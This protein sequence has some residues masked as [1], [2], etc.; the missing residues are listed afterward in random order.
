MKQ[1]AFSSS[2][3][4]SSEVQLESIDAVRSQLA[5]TAIIFSAIIG[6]IVLAASLFREMAI[7]RQGVMLLPVGSGLV[8]LAFLIFFRR[9]SYNIRAF[10]IP[11]VLFIWGSIGLFRFGLV[12]MGIP[13]L[14]TSCI[15]ITIFLGRRFGLSALAASLGVIA[16]IG[17][18]IQQGQIDFMV[19]MSTYAVTPYA[20]ILAAIC[21][22]FCIGLIVVT[23]G[24]LH[25]SLVDSI[26]TLRKRSS[27]LQLTNEQLK[28]EITERKQAG[29]ELQ[30]LAS[31]IR[32]SS[33]L[34][35]LATLDG[36]MIFLNEAGS[37]MLGIEP[38]DV[39]KTDI[40]EVIPDH[41]CDL[42]QQE[43][44]PALIAQRTWE[45][46]LQYRNIKTGELT[47][48]HAMTFTIQDLT[49]GE[50][51]YLANVSL[52][53]TERKQ[54]EEALRQSEERYRQLADLLPQVVFEAD[55]KGQ[56]TFANRIAFDLF[57]Y[58]EDDFKQGLDALQMLIPED[59]DKALE[60]V[61]RILEGEKSVGTEY[62][63]L[64]K[65]G[66]TYP[67]LISAN[68]VISEGK[69]V[70]IR[71][72][73]SDL[74]EYKRAQEAL[75]ESEEKLRTIFENASDFIIWVDENGT[76]ID[77]NSKIK[78]M[79]GYKRAEVIGKNFAEF[80]IFSPEAMQDVIREVDRALKS[81]DTKLL[82]LE[83]TRKDGVSVPVE[84]S[85]KVIQSTKGGLG[86][87][88]A[89][90]D[91][92]ERKRAEEEKARLETQLQQAKK[93]E[94]IGTLAGGVAH[95]LNNVLSGIVGYPDLLLMQL[96]EG[97]PLKKPILT[98]QDTGRKAAAIVQ[99]LLTLARRGVSVSE[100]ANLNTI[101][102]EYLNSPEYGK[103]MS[104][105]PGVEVEVNLDTDLLNVQA[106][107][108]HL[109]KTIMNLTSNAAEAMTEGGKLSISTKNRYIDKP[110]KGYDYIEEGDYAV[111]MV[112]DT[113]T[114]MTSEDM[115]RIFEPFYTKKKMGKS[116]TGLGM[117]VVWGTVKD[118]G[119]YIETQS[120]VGK[121]TTFSLYF[122]VTRQK[123]APDETEIPE[124]YYKG[125]GETIL[126]VD[127]VKVQ[128][129]VAFSMLSELGYSVS[130]ASSG[131]EAIEYLKNNAVDLLI[132]DMIMDPGMDGLDTYKQILQMNPAQKAIITSGFSESARVKEVQ[133]L[134][135]GKYIKKP[136]QLE[137]IGIAIKNELDKG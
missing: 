75:R 25:G 45:G 87:L 32:Y 27:E 134:G 95:D 66:S 19:D 49:T 71:G 26:A 50:P 33:E 112:S 55:E 88:A 102:E 72:V 38:E 4:N 2:N 52:D 78:D 43:L 96:P 37:K 29:I 54:T 99:D 126:I 42:V 31:V 125:N 86:V 3:I 98:I 63:V 79:V 30:K 73:V 5:N 53:I 17:V 113:G 129:E 81:G 70:G 111:L 64:K 56:L 114:G 118:H 80:P 57:G 58:T 60:K 13:A 90:R 100:V 83:V 106:S 128:R 18:G 68:P 20:W 136:Y 105:H 34:V 14:I 67:A 61:L 1:D 22:A 109:S 24:L 93:M 85:A 10:M 116:G 16:I 137:E 124:E 44:F 133:R 46:D 121:G 76:I 82:E 135:A 51:L 91:I 23:L 130:T 117:A 92:S 127:D 62:T 119:G 104:F 11:G 69:S 89:I 101:I 59:R 122:P 107:P 77:V 74:S 6:I 21:S 28:S 39:E 7:G 103:L 108:V 36:K 35:N 47:D 8:V 15:L 120:T 65:D 48:V 123:P 12:G 40:M 94:A 110:I 131:E 41:L 115:E 132:L 97:S 9:L 84:V